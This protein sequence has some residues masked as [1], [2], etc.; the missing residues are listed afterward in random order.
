MAPRAQLQ[1][2]L[3]EDAMKTPTTIDACRDMADEG[4]RLL[5]ELHPAPYHFEQV[6]G[7]SGSEWMLCNARGGFATCTDHRVA[8]ALC[9]MLTAYGH[10]QAGKGS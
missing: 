4:Y 7:E 9:A 8:E 3:R 5:A 10:M 6:G 1:A 2:V